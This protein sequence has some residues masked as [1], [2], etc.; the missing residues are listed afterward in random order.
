VLRV[1]GHK[2]SELKALS[3]FIFIFIF[4]FYSLFFVYCN[5]SLRPNMGFNVSA[6]Y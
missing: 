3:F 2:I 1:G 4:I 6:I 5:V